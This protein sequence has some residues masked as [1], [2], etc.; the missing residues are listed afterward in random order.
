MRKRLSPHLVRRVA[1]ATLAISLAACG[2]GLSPA[3]DP[4]DARLR[5][6]AD[7]AL[8]RWSAAVEAA[9]SAQAFV[10]VGELTGQIGDWEETVGGNNKSA[11]MAGMVEAP[12]PPPLDR[13]P[14]GEVVWPDGSADA[15]A[16]LSAQEAVIEM[17]S[18]QT[19][20]CPEC[21]PLEVTGA[22]VVDLP[23]DTSRGR[24]IVP[25]W[26]FTVAG[27]AVEVT[28]VAVAGRVNLVVP[29]WDPINSPVGLSIDSATG[30]V[31]ALTLTVTFVGAPEP[32]S[33]PCGADYTA[34][35]VE[36]A[37]AVVVIVH[38]HRNPGGGFCRAVG[39][40][41]S[42]I[43]QLAAPLGDRAVLEVKQGL[44]VQAILVR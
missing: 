36:S 26:A 1:T 38:E 31:G 37:T 40:A 43:V 12:V 34:E 27:T 33:Q 18:A 9:G 24:A 5:E 32:A 29:P 13:P 42:A 19:G 7:A 44:P 16:L 15:V 23:F 4:N 6:Q 10:P 30:T 8:A 25:T 39:A 3:A 20:G 17:Q 21:T 14:D 2:G 22:H 28:R 41:R 11:L 35:A